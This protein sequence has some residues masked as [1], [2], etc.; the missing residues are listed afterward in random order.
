MAKIIALDSADGKT[1]WR[2]TPTAAT[3]ADGGDPDL[4][5]SDTLPPRRFPAA[6][7]GPEPLQADAGRL[8]ALARLLTLGVVSDD[9]G[10]DG[11]VLVISDDTAHWTHVSAGE[12]ISTLA[13]VTPSLARMLGAKGLLDQQA[14]D[15]VMTRP[16]RLTAALASAPQHAVSHLVGADLAA[17]RRWWLGHEVR[18]AGD[19]PLAQAYSDALMTQGAPVA[20][21]DINTATRRGLIALA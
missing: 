1:L 18:L 21:T 5:V 15:E 17:A 8:P 11:I 12:A 10:W 4:T 16:E 13:T 2:V 9:Q 20:P 14:L 19:G 7:R 6:L 3:P